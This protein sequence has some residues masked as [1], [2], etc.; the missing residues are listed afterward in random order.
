M[1]TSEKQVLTSSCHYK[2]GGW[3]PI[4]SEHINTKVNDLKG[5]LPT[6]GHDLKKEITDTT[7]QM[8]W[9]KSWLSVKI[10]VL[11]QILSTC[12]LNHSLIWLTFL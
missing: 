2:G 6:G 12:F 5:L 1:T 11:G 9:G 3:F 4:Q 10:T 8:E 7:E